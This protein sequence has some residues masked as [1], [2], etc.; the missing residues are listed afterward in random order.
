MR[1][2]KI[3]EGMPNEKSKILKYNRGQKFMKFPFLIYA[4]SESLLKK[5]GNC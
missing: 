1:H 2:A 3:I 4:S 5:I